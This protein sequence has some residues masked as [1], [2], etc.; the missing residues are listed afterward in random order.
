VNHSRKLSGWQVTSILFWGILLPII[1][2]LLPIIGQSSS[3][4]QSWTN[5]NTPV[6]GAIGSPNPWFEAPENWAPGVPD[7]NSLISFNLDPGYRYEVWWDAFAQSSLPSVGS[8]YFSAGS[9]RFRNVEVGGPQLTLMLGASHIFPTTLVVQG[10]GTSLEIDGLNVTSTGSATIFDGAS[11]SLLNNHPA[12]TTLSVFGQLTLYGSLN[13]DP[14]SQLNTYSEGT[15]IDS[16]SGS[17]GNGNL[18]L[19]AAQWNSN[20]NVV[21]GQHGSGAISI[22]NGGSLLSNADITLADL[23][24]SSGIFTISNLG[25]QVST[26][27]NVIIGNSGHGTLNIE[28]G[29]KFTAPAVTL[30]NTS[31]GNGVL[32]INGS[33]SELSTFDLILGNLGNGQIQIANGGILN[34]GIGTVRGQVLVSGSGSQWNTSSALLNQT[35][36]TVE[37]GGRVSGGSS[38]IDGSIIS[39]SGANSEFEF[40]NLSSQQSSILVSSGGG[41]TV[42]SAY[43][44]D[45]SIQV[46]GE[47]SYWLSSGPVTLDGSSGSSLSIASS[48]SVNTGNF[49]IADFVNYSGNV[50]VSGG[51]SL[52]V[53]GNLSVGA[54]GGNAGVDIASGGRVSVAAGGNTWIGL[55]SSVVV[56]NGT[57]DAGN[58]F[59]GSFGNGSAQLR[60]ENG[61]Q[62]TS[63]ASSVYGQIS[64]DGTGSSWNFSN[65]LSLSQSNL[66]VGSGGIVSG[67]FVNVDFSAISVTGVGS[68]INFGNMFSQQSSVVISNGGRLT[69]SAAT[70][71]DCGIQITGIDSGWLSSGPVTL[72][73]FGQNSLLLST[74]FANIGSL[75]VASSA[76][77]QGNVSVIANGSLFVD[78]NL[79]LGAAGGNA[80]MTIQS[81]SVFVAGGNTLIGSNSSVNLHG[82][83]F[84]FSETTLDSYSRISGTSGSLAGAI[85][86]D[87]YRTVASL[88]PIQ[89]SVFDIS[90]VSIANAGSLVGDGTVNLD[91]RNLTTGEVET[92]VGERL[93]F[94]GFNNFNAGEINNFNGQIRF[95]HGLRNE[96]FIGGRGEFVANGGWE[97]YGVMAFS[98]GNADILGDVDMKSGSLI[99]TTGGATSTFFDDVIHNGSEIR[100]SINSQSVFLGSVT[101][102]GNFTGGGTVY[103]EGD[104]R[105]GNS[106]NVIS[107][108]GNLVFGSLS[109]LHVELGGTSLGEFDQLQ[110]A[111]NLFVDGNL[112]VDLIGGHSLG[113]N[114]QYLLADIGGTRTGFW[115]GLGEGSLVGNFGGHDLFITYT[116]GNGSGIALFT[117]VPEPGSFM[118][119]VGVW[120]LTIVLRNRHRTGAAAPSELPS[121]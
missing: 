70:F 42:N 8:L 106:P 65:G 97:N 53:N 120:L 77:D 30:G 80:N 113:L 72:Y 66:A 15:F 43:L 94:T 48:G 102:A 12:G 75:S 107:F 1:G 64:V 85:R 83:T 58:L 37:A 39:V 22:T 25:T 9:A 89:S 46:V 51:G 105:P 16:Y 38:T 19:S 56:N 111:G 6:G 29:A 98:S 86:I 33:G 4:A 74:G 54:N 79:S 78:G 110:I 36:L 13:L 14:G 26:T 71:F 28:S 10:I 116:A 24:D 91:F 61:G 76:G 121:I 50:S 63:G 68:E 57:L 87:G 2:Q 119:V 5:S 45:S 112:V 118:L 59:V 21:V 103:F 35:S 32:S 117:A 11:L 109:T 100:T 90:G 99:V 67:G 27:G 41:V 88:S 101:G 40:D 69:T 73:G 44:F 20:G 84:H 104:L 47:N 55:N 92:R 114:Q 95:D 82:G 108:G 115:N 3:W 93:R 49:S 81:G 7:A 60:V 96:G 18:T 62:V 23:Q 34:S 31:S 52:D 17:F